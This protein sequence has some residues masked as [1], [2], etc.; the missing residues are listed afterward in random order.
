MIGLF[1]FFLMIRRTPRSTRTDT[2]FPYT[3]LFRSGGASI[4]AKGPA[5][6]TYAREPFRGLAVRR[7]SGT[8]HSPQE[9]SRYRRARCAPIHDPQCRSI[10][11]NKARFMVGNRSE[12]SSLDHSRGSDEDEEGA[13]RSALGRGRINSQAPE[14]GRAHV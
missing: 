4:G 6:S 7:R 3:T 11:R 1:R 9:A 8:C 12:R 2:L 10:R 13:C 5:S 14:I